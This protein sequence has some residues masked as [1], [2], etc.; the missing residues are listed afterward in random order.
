MAGNASNHGSAFLRLRGQC[1][2]LKLRQAAAVMP[3]RAAAEA[4]ALM[5]IKVVNTN[6][7][8]RSGALLPVLGNVYFYFVTP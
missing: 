1:S 6:V 3:L 4:S 5:S 8:S 7:S 2:E